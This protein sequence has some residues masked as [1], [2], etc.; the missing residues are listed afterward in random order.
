MNLPGGDTPP[1]GL[2]TIRARGPGGQSLSMPT[3]LARSMNSEVAAHPLFPSPVTSP[4]SLPRSLPVEPVCVGAAAA[5]A[6]RPSPPRSP[7]PT[8]SGDC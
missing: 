1:G 4:G 8:L 3:D 6:L 7:H 2:C 5:D